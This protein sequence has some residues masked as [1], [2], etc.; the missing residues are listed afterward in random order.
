MNLN[1]IQYRV[2]AEFGFSETAILQALDK[3]KFECA[4]DLVE[5]LLDNANDSIIEEKDEDVV[6]CC[7]TKQLK[8]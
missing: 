3:H 2:A 1:S 8:I 4:G 6:M 7:N 5:Y